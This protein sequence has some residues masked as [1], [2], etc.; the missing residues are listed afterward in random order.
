MSIN[1]KTIIER[2]VKEEL[3]LMERKYPSAADIINSGTCA[4]EDDY[5]LFYHAAP[6]RIIDA[7][8]SEGIR[9]GAGDNFSNMK[10][11]S[12]GKI[13]LSQGYENGQKWQSML[14]DQLGE[15][16]GI[17]E[18]SLTDEQIDTLELDSKSFDEGDICSFFLRGSLSPSQIVVIDRGE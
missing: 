4:D 5:W 12:T 15:P 17:I 14:E 13:F 16:V 18:V 6:S 8:E 2:L 7:I 10:N 1:L 3:L 9:P 11:W